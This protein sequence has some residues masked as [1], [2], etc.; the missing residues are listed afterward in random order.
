MLAGAS[1]NIQTSQLLLQLLDRTKYNTIFSQGFKIEKS[2]LFNTGHSAE[3]AL[4]QTGDVRE[5]LFF[6]L[7]QTLLT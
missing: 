4:E 3:V 7:G 6:D 5:G 2:H 1:A